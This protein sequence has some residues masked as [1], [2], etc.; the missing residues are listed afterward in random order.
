MDS[1]HCIGNDHWKNYSNGSLKKE[2]FLYINSHIQTC[3]ICKDI[4]DGIDLME[5]KNSLSTIVLNIDKKVDHYLKPDKRSSLFFWYWSAAAV[6]IFSIGITL[7]IFVQK[8]SNDFA[9]NKTIPLQ[10]IHKNADSISQKISQSEEVE[11]QRIKKVV[12]HAVK[13]VKSIEIAKADSKR[14]SDETLKEIEKNNAV[15]MAKK[16][17]ALSI[18]NVENDLSKSSTDD[19]LKTE[20]KTRADAKSISDKGSFNSNSKYERPSTPSAANNNYRNNQAAEIFTFNESDSIQL[21]HAQILYNNQIYDSCIMVL[22]PMVKNG[23]SKL[24]EDALYLKANAE[25]QLHQNDSAQK[26]L[27]TLIKLNGR[28]KKEAQ[29]LLKTL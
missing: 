19:A 12:G 23:Y 16:A 14:I 18:E 27:R 20:E 6:L 24:K 4:K 2:D 9:L 15:G 1:T 10:E 3:E 28:R 11:N 5:Q 26:T 29:L 22:D 25:L 7:Y 17:D 13:D 21:K 8:P